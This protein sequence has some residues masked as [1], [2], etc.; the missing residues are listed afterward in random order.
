MRVTLFVNHACNLRC[1]YCYNGDKFHAAMP[2]ETALSGVDLALSQPGPARVS[3]F[4]GEPLMELD[5]IREVH[6]Y[7]VELARSRRRALGYLMVTNATLLSEPVLDELFERRIRVAVSLDGSER[8]HDSA[9]VFANGQGSWRQASAN[10]ARLFAR[11]PTAKVIAVIHP[12]NVQWLAESFDA[13]LGLGARNISMNVDYESAWDEPARDALVAAL[14]D[15]G[16]AYA[17]AYRRG[18]RFTL[19]LIDSK[20]ITHIKG[21]YAES[22]WCDFGMEEV[23]VAPS[24]RL[25]PCDRLVGMDDREDLVIGTVTGGI[26]VERRDALIREKNTVLP[27][28]EDC[29]LRH[30]CMNWCGCVNYAMTQQ[31]G[32]VDGLLC[33][34]EQVTVDAADR[35]AEALFAEENPLFLGRFY[36]PRLRRVRLDVPT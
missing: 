19:N 36:A 32:E 17:A 5:L 15:L 12:G 18:E 20:I 26:D 6:D 16:E 13:L 11:T 30:R 28:C 22:D 10:A 1:T 25:Y 23:A 35:V 21:G 31:V 4:G 27:E 29:A 8:A 14:R 2:L 33:W 34:L 9:R 24:G 7:A 3:F